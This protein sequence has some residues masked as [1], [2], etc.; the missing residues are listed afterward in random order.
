MVTFDATL[1]GRE[2]A[3]W[4]ELLGSTSIA[5]LS[6]DIDELVVIAAH[7][8]DETLGAGGLIAAASDRGIPVRVVVITDGAASHAD[9]GGLDLTAVR[10]DELRQAIDVLAPSAGIVHLG[11]PDG[12]TREHRPEITADLV[13]LLATTGPRALV[14][15]PWPG[16]GHRDHRVV[17]EIVAELVQRVVQYPIW[18]WHW[19]APGDLPLSELAAVHVDGPRK[20]QAI[21]AYE[22]QIRPVGGVTVLTEHFLQHFSADREVFIVPPSLTVGYFDDL[23]ERNP[24]PWRFESRWYERRKRA[25][26]AASLPRERYGSVLEIGCSTG[27]VT[28][29]LADRSDDVLA[30][31]VAQAAVERARAR[32]GDRARVLVHDV[33]TGIPGG[34][35]DLVVLS[36]VGYYLT[37][38]QLATLLD[39]IEAA[40]GTDGTLLACHWRHPVADY[41]LT[42]D[43][44]H[45][46]IAARGLPRT[47]RHEEEDFVL[48]AFSRDA[49]SVARREGFV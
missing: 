21:A 36:E 8:D 24:D 38:P 7:P 37:E 13:R 4:R 46:A 15:A 9:P 27:H 1:P 17:G 34:P 33:T 2:A 3:E 49:R 35:F 10:A 16:D 42:G 23:Y 6:L 44:V 31:D 29:V 32:V 14:V 26:I 45:A 41:P 47:A 25:L 40:L 30:V 11:Y 43:A 28:E 20:A 5:D 18:F 39:E 19:G 22:S 48:E 12:A